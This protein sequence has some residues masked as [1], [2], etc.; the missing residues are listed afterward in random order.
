[1]LQLHEN[2]SD[3]RAQSAQPATTAEEA[4]RENNVAD[5]DVG[6]RLAQEYAGKTGEELFAAAKECAETDPEKSAR[7]LDMASQA[8]NA[9]A[10]YVIANFL[11][12]DNP[13]LSQRM[14]EEAIAQGDDYAAPYE[15][16]LMLR[17]SDP[18][19]AKEL[20]G[21]AVEAGNPEAMN[22]LGFLIQGED[23]EAAKALFERAIEAGEEL[24]AYNNLALLLEND[25]LDRAVSLFEQAIEHGD[26]YYAPNNLA[27]LIQDKNRARAIKLYEQAIEAG[28]VDY[29]PRNLAQFIAEEDPDRAVRLLA[30]A[31]DENHTPELDTPEEFEFLA[32]YYRESD[33]ALAKEYYQRA[34]AFGSETAAESLASL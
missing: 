1:M 13:E 14:Y 5:A 30:Q 22:T 19:R 18:A 23:R 8:G 26:T 21:K 28:D 20:L 15:L 31:L 12:D 9:E 6:A 25:D 24:Y 27:R 7:L 34:I 10:S 4:S 17:E 32:D 16:A 3:E 33:P 11:Q 2:N 29:A